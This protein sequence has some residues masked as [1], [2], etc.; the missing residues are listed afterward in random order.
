MAHIFVLAFVLAGGFLTA[1]KV[2]LDGDPNRQLAAFDVAGLI[3]TGLPSGLI[4]PDQLVDFLRGTSNQTGD[5]L[6][7]IGASHLV[8]MG[9][10]VWVGSVE[11]MLVNL[12][13]ASDAE[14]QVDLRVCRVSAAFAQGQLGDLLARD[15]NDAV[16]VGAEPIQRVVGNDSVVRLIRAMLADPSTQIKQSPQVT[17]RQLQTA[18]IRVGRDV[19]YVRSLT[20]SPV[21]TGSRLPYRSSISSGKAMTPKSSSLSLVKPRLPS[22]WTC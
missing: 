19:G 2:M 3:E 6:S 10:P 17:V 8:A 11:S 5:S 7:A 9:S 21:P 16:V 12:R 13:K 20:C 15:G 22:R 4:S 18:R 14:F 1:Q